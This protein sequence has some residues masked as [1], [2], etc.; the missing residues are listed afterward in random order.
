[1]KACNLLLLFLITIGSFAQTTWDG[2]SWSSGT[3]DNTIDAII[4]GSY[5]TSLHGEFTA[6][7]LSVAVTGS[8]IVQPSTS[9]TVHTNLDNLGSFT[10]ED[11]GT[12]LMIDDSGTVFGNYAVNRD[13]PDYL[14]IG[15]TSFFSSPVIEDDSNITSIFNSSDVI[16]YWD[17]SISPTNWI[18]IPHEES[19]GVSNKLG[20]GKGY[21]V[22]S[23]VE[24]GVITRTFTGEL[25]TG[26]ISVPV[27]Y[28]DSST[29]PGQFGYNIVGNPY[30]SAIDWFAFKD[31]NSSILS[32]TMYLWR[33]QATGGVNHASSYIAL[34]ALGVVPYNSANEFIGSAQGFVVKTNSDSNV[35][36]KNSHRVTNN[37]QFFRSGNRRNTDNNSWLKIEGAGNKSTILVGF[38]VNATTGFDNDYDGIFIGGTDPLQLYSLNGTDKLLINGLPELVAPNDVSVALGIKSATTGSFT[39]S[40]EEE[41]I[42]PDFL[43]KLEDTQEMIITDLRS[44]DYTFTV[45]NTAANESRFVLY[46]E[47]D[48]SLS[49][50]DVQI[51]E[52]KVKAFFK[53]DELNI[54][55][56]VNMSPSSMSIYDL[57]GNEI[58][59]GA[60]NSR[61]LTYG[62]SSGIYLIELN[63]KE[64]GRVYK[65]VIKQ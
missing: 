61:T 35:V 31:D 38:H 1:M 6:K 12:L 48:T 22:R 15:W 16:F 64:Y 17:T 9:I 63:F 25:N 30:P 59:K 57:M 65:T 39:I 19:P 43:I 42:S 51:D 46:Y 26:D 3:P 55:V 53:H 40:L 4:T 21:A 23:D 62:L 58:L 33:Q 14:T 8:I 11:K 36:F 7:N 10:I 20:L 44:I 60:F 18:F 29:S 41:F 34:N 5:D 2:T 52:N 47:Y 50:D 54:M 13:T 45:N 28:S 37:E 56:N 32:G 24:T 27:Y 49:N